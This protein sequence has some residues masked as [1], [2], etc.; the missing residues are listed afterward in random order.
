MANI[1]SIWKQENI[2]HEKKLKVIKEQSTN[3]K[4]MADKINGLIGANLSNKFKK[5]VKEAAKDQY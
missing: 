2:S 5:T 1:Q 4:M 3:I